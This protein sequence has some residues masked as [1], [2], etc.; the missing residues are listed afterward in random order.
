MIYIATVTVVE[1]VICLNDSCPFCRHEIRSVGPIR[2]ISYCCIG[3]SAVG[4]DQLFALLREND[5][6]MVILS[7]GSGSEIE[8]LV[9]GDGI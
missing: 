4:V 9:L 6:V 8:C 2:P 7:G 5:V 3:R 1:D